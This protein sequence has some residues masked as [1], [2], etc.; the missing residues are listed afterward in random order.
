ME[1]SNWRKL[2]QKQIYD[3]LSHRYGLFVIVIGL[4]L[5]VTS[6]F[7]FGESVVEWSTEKYASVFN[8]FSDNLAGKSYRERL[9]LPVPIDVVYTWVNGTDSLLIRRLQRVKLDMQDQLNSSREIKCVFSNC[10]RN[11]MVVLSPAVEDTITLTLLG[12]MT[13]GFQK[14]KNMF[15]VTSPIDLKNY[16]VVVF[17]DTGQDSKLQ[18]VIELRDQILMSGFPHTL[19]TEELMQKLPQKH[20]DR[21]EKMEVDSDKGI[22]V[23]YARSDK[24]CSDI[25]AETNFT[26]D[27]KEPTLSAAQLVWDLR[28][29]SRDEDV[30]ASRFEDNEELR[31]SLRSLER[32]APWVRHVYIVTNGQLPYWL[33]LENPRITLVTH[34]E[35]FQNK[36]HL[37]SFSSPAIESN[38][39]RIP[40]LSDKFIYMNDDVMFGKEVWP[41]DF[42]THSSG[43]KDPT[44]MWRP[45]REDGQEVGAEM[46]AQIIVT[47]AVPTTGLQTDTACNVLECGYDA[48]DCGTDKY[49]NMYGLGYGYFNL[50]HLLPDKNTTLKDAFYDDNKI[51]RTIAVAKKFHVLTIV[52]YSNMSKTEINFTLEYGSDNRTKQLNL[53]LEVDTKP[54]ATAVAAVKPVVGKN[55]SM[56]S[57]KTVPMPTVETIE[58]HDIP[59]DQIGPVIMLPTKSPDLSVKYEGLPA[60][61]TSVAWPPHLKLQ[62]DQLQQE[63]QQEELTEIGYRLRV[64]LLWLDYQEFLK[65]PEA[66]QAKLIEQVQGFS[67]E[68]GNVE[69]RKT[70]GSNVRDI[71]DRRKGKSREAGVVKQAE[72]NGHGIEKPSEDTPNFPVKD[73]ISAKKRLENII[74][75]K[76]E[77][78]QAKDP[79]ALVND[80]KSDEKKKNNDDEVVDDKDK[81]IK[82][83]DANAGGKRRKLLAWVNDSVV[84]SASEE[85]ELENNGMQRDPSEGVG[86]SFVEFVDIQPDTVRLLPWEKG[87]LRDLQQAFGYGARKV[88]GHMPHMIDRNIMTELQAR[89]PAE[90]EATSSHQVRHSKDM[91]FAFSYFYYLM[92]VKEN[93]T[94]AQVFDEM[95]TD[96]SRILSDR[97][98]R[99]LATRLYD[100][101]LDLQTLTSLELMFVNCSKSLTSEQQTQPGISDLE[102]YYEKQ[103]PQVTR[104]LFINCHEVRKLVL[105]K[106]PPKNK[107]RHVEVDDSEIAFKMIKTNVSSVVGQLDDVRKNPKKFIC[108]NDNID[109]HRQDQARTV[110]AIIA[111]FYESVFPLQSQFELPREYRNRFTHIDELREWRNYRDWLKFWT[112]LALVLLV[113]EAAQR[114]YLRRRSPSPDSSQ[115]EQSCVDQGHGGA[116]ETIHCT[117]LGALFIVWLHFSVNLFLFLFDNSNSFDLNEWHWFAFYMMGQYEKFDS[118]VWLALEQGSSVIH[119]YTYMF[120]PQVFMFGEL[121]SYSLT[122]TGFCFRELLIFFFIIPCTLQHLCY[123]K[124]LK[125]IFI[126]YVNY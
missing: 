49:T 14:A 86:D 90:W 36:S 52:L 16:T 42:Y 95:D 101:P 125:L 97:E 37:P 79:Q 47:P 108:L 123:N 71:H 12:V 43:Q 15:K 109:H 7:H 61:L 50:T 87:A 116:I 1:S 75:V 8:S 82:A 114:R 27:G 4:I 68:V 11:N 83:L 110:K 99:T 98:I 67:K 77:E 19:S 26:L 44:Q 22:A 81:V 119:M 30:S 6:A 28:D 35:I 64:K 111:D 46:A 92:G 85:V 117:V 33:N 29:F 94:A 24:D 9:C 20:Q 112:H 51:I 80:E 3:I 18:N 54:Q 62:F 25:L 69:K 118:F 10:V 48:G 63:L 103:M 57:N 96:K 39:H 41:D 105:A 106:F 126:C 53:T 72:E 121:F 74:D 88:P 60:N 122:K 32:F 70:Q 73:K 107:Y 100:L 104:N 13:P 113:I 2:I 58:F 5:I 34:D 102:S 56:V 38:L 84:I 78:K 59:D 89:F 93:V 66:A 91:Q 55:I 76:S 45:K 65:L 23:L 31:Y 124:M 120:L 115:S 17:S 21:I 40:G